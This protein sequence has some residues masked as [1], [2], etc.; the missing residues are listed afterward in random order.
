M[1][2]V[3]LLETS[4]DYDDEDDDDESD[5]DDDIVDP[6]TFDGKT[7]SQTIELSKMLDATTTKNGYQDIDDD[8]DFEDPDARLVVKA[9][10]DVAVDF[11]VQ[12]YPD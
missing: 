8:N 2:S 6:N 10:L 3:D 5:G 12:L 4:E 11:N 1:V 9:S 7:A